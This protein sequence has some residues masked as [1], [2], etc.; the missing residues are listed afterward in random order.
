M[1]LYYSAV[2][3][4]FH[5]ADFLAR[6]LAD[7]PDTPTSP[8]KS[9]RGCRRGCRCREMLRPDF[10]AD[11]PARILAGMSAS[12]SVSASWNARFRTLWRFTNCCVNF[13]TLY[14]LYS[15]TSES[16]FLFFLVTC[17]DLFRKKFVGIAGPVV[18][19]M[20]FLRCWLLLYIINLLL[21]GSRNEWLLRRII[22]G[23]STSYSIE[24]LKLLETKFNSQLQHRFS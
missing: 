21:F 6:I 22:S 1:T 15:W 16:V 13:R 23:H 18:L 8:R 12:V 10:L 11:I 14:V 3:P 7:S 5:D 24:I 20:D 4:A 17:C 19:R 2:K 9:S